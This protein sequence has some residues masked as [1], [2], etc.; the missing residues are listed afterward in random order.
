MKPIKSTLPATP[1]LEATRQRDAVGGAQ[2]SPYRGI[3][4]ATHWPLLAQDA[5]ILQLSASELARRIQ[6]REWRSEDVVR[7]FVGQIARHNAAYNAVVLLDLD[8][9]LERARAADDALDRG[10]VWGPLHG[11]PV[12]VKDTYAIQGLRTTAGDPDLL[13]YVP[14]EDAVIVSLLRRAGAIVLAKTNAATLAMDMQTT[15]AIFGTT[16]NP[17]DVKRTVG[18]S[19][20][21]CA[22]AVASHMSA[23]SFGSDL[24]GSIRL[25]AAYTGI[26]GLRPTHGVISMAGHMPPKPDEVN[27]MRVMAVAGP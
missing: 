22:A 17:W 25:P 12:T 3:P 16:N 11:V 7:A 23:L 20:G 8:A 18:G 1:S 5:Q 10:E 14:E 6:A 26:W 4:D 9:S 15:N 21:G 24:A 2:R 13:N 19:S 27:G